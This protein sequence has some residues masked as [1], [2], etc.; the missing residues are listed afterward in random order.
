M[1]TINND[2]FKV[3]KAPAKKTPRVEAE[4]TKKEESNTRSGF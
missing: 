3:K 1:T 2:D 4:A